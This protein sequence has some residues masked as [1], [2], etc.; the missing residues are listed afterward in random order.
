MNEAQVRRKFHQL[1]MIEKLCRYTR[2]LDPKCKTYANNIT[3]GLLR[4]LYDEFAVELTNSKCDL[5]KNISAQMYLARTV[6]FSRKE[7]LKHVN[8]KLNIV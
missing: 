3:E 4:D 7:I 1:L 6:G 5:A 2:R 8:H